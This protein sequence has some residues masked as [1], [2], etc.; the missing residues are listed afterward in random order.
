MTLQCTGRGG[1]NNFFQWTRN[2]DDVVV[3][4]TS[5]LIFQN[6][7]S[8]EGGIYMCTVFNSAGSDSQ[9]AT[10]SCKLTK[11]IYLVTIY[12]IINFLVFPGISTLPVDTSSV[13]SGNAFFTCVAFGPPVPTIEWLFNGGPLTTNHRVLSN[14][15]RHDQVQSNLTILMTNI[16]DSGTYTCKAS[17]IGGDSVNES[18]ILTV[19]GNTSL[20]VL[21]TKFKQFFV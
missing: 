15:P 9:T 17:N 16:S 10:I 8:A 11:I 21:V 13:S 6:I 20:N 14:N 5:T 2:R 19:Q 3:R 18:A 4:N 7:S 12:I 1:P